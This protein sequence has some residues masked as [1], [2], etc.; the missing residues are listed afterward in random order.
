MTQDTPQPGTLNRN[1]GLWGLVPIT[2]GGAVRSGIPVL[3]ATM[4]SVA[5]SAVV[6]AMVMLGAVVIL[7][8]LPYAQLGAAFPSTSGPGARRMT[9]LLERSDP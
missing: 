3:A 5:G 7:L 4:S 9:Y 6:V 1:V 2:A 8:A